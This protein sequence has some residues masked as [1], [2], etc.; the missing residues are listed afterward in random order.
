MSANGAD[1]ANTENGDLIPEQ[2]HCLVQMLKDASTKK[3]PKRR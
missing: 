1:L 3:D 2:P